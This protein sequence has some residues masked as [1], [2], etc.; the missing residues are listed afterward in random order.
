[1]GSKNTL[2]DTLSQLLDVCPE[3][4]LNPEPQGQEFGCYCFEEMK[5]VEVEY[6]EEVGLVR[7]QENENLKEIKLPCKTHKSNCCSD[8]TRHVEKSQRSYSR[9]SI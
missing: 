4:K 3:A 5:P 8:M 2:A 9:R 6:I 1:M 7:I